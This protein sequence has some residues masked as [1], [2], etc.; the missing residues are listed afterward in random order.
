MST[1]GIYNCG[2]TSL[3]SFTSG[4]RSYVNPSNALTP[5]V[6]NTFN[7]GDTIFTFTTVTP[8][9]YSF[10]F[11]GNLYY[12]N[13][14]Y[15]PAWWNTILSSS[16]TTFCDVFSYGL[17]IGSSSP[18]TSYPNYGLVN[19]SLLLPISNTTNL[20]LAISGTTNIYPMD[21][22]SLYNYTYSLCRIV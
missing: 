1:S 3:P 6:N 19:I 2:Y 5:I 18:A 10:N 20:Q 7:N 16:S 11:T 14:S 22:F 21:Y 8:G 9:I 17:S 15:I 12:S 4:S 13:P